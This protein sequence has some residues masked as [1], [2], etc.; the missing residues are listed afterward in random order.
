MMI[1]PVGV[2]EHH[3]SGVGE[4]LGRSNAGFQVLGEPPIA[5]NPRQ[6]T[7]HHPTVGMDGEAD[8]VRVLADDLYGDAGLVRNPVCCVGAVCESALMKGKTRREALSSGKAPSRS[9]IEA[10][11]AWSTNARPSV[12]TRA[13]RLRPFTFLPAS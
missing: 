6:E 11:W 8:F 7:L 4:G 13:A 3:R 9:W 5:A 2:E 10:A 1:S 12:S